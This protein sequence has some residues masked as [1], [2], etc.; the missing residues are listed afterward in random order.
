M[1]RS[2]RWERVDAAAV[3]PDGGD[4]PG[5][6]ERPGPN[7]SRPELDAWASK[8]GVENPESLPNKAAVV[9]AIEQ[10][11]AASEAGDPAGG[12]GSTD[13]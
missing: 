1:D 13:W 12:E 6:E 10:A 5:G 9:E 8:V 3:E 11:E 4:G 2:K 7:A